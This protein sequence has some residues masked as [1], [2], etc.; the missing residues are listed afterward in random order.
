MTNYHAV[1]NIVGVVMVVYLCASV[2]KAIR[3]GKARAGDPS[4]TPTIP[5]SRHPLLFWTI[6]AAQ[7]L[8][9]IVI[10]IAVLLFAIRRP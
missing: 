9:G 3:T 10:L 5:R 2:W 8:V 7:I 4:T 1:L 6:I